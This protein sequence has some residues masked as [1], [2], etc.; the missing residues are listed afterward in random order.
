ML[1]IAIESKDR[2]IPGKQ[3]SSSLMGPENRMILFTKVIQI[4]SDPNRTKGEIMLRKVIVT[5]IAMLFVF[6]AA[7]AIL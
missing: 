5:V 3:V 7:G 4:N 1:T 6:T 2:A